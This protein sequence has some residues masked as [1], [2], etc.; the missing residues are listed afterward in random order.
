MKSFPLIVGLILVLTYLLVGFCMW[1]FHAMFVIAMNQQ[2]M[3]LIRYLL[4]WPT[5]LL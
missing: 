2:P 5:L 4:I 1:I 3:G